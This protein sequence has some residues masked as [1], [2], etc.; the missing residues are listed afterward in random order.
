MHDTIF[1]FS[2]LLWCRMELNT[3]IS[4]FKAV[5]KYLLRVFCCYAE[6]SQIVLTAHLIISCNSPVEWL[7][8]VFAWPID[9]EEKL[10][11][12]CQV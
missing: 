8:G 2:G 11:S 4:K 9:S 7:Q 1:V 10:E 3:C 6:L 12:Y 5:S